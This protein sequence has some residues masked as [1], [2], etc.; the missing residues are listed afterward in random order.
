MKTLACTRILT[1]LLAVNAGVLWGAP[2]AANPTS[3]TLPSPTSYSVI[4]RDANSRVWERTVYE[5]GP[6]GQAIPKK[7]NYIELATGLHYWQN[8]QWQESQELIESFPGGAIARQGQHK[9][10]FANN[11]ATVGAIDMQTPDGKRMRSHVLG[12][13]YFDAASGQ[14][15][16]IAEVKDSLGQ[17]Y[18]PNVV[19]YSD[20][21]TD[22]KADV[23]YTYTR[24]GFEQDII[25]HERPPGP[26]AFGLNPATTR[27]QV[28]TEFL[29]PPQPVKK[30]GSLKTRSGEALDEDLDFGTMR[31]GQ[32]KAF[33]L[34]RGG[35][36]IPV[37]KQWLKLEG[38]DFLVEEVAVPELGEQ[39][40]A[41]PAAEGASLNPAADSVR[42]VVSK[43]RLL[44]ALRVVQA[45][46]NEMQLARLSLPSQ[47]LVL[48][49]TTLNSSQTSYT[50][51]GDTT[52]YISG[53]V[54]LSGTNTFEGGSVIKYD[55]GAGIGVV[56]VNPN[57]KTSPYRPVIFTA[58][59]DDSV[60][61]TI[62][63][64]SGNPSGYYAN[65]ALQIVAVHS[66]VQATMSNVRFAYATNALYIWSTLLTISN[67]QF[68]NCQYPVEL[69]VG[70]VFIRNALFSTNVTTFWEVAGYTPAI[71]LQNVTVNSA[72]HLM[73]ASA[74]VNGGVYCLTNCIFANVTGT[75]YGGIPTNYTFVCSYNGF[76]NCQHFGQNQVVDN[77]YPFQ[78]VGAG[79]YYLTNGCA[80]LNAGTK[81]IDPNL[82]AVIRTKTTRPPVTLTNAIRSSTTLGPVVPRDVDVPDL[83]Y[84]YD[85]IDYLSSCIVSNATLTINNGAVLA[86]NYSDWAYGGLWLQEGSQLISQ[87][88]ADKRNYIVDYRTA[89]EE[90]VKFWTTNTITQS[91]W[92]SKA[93][94]SFHTNLTRNPGINLNFTTV[95]SQNG[96]VYLLCA[97]NSYFLLDTLK[98]ANCELYA[99]GADVC[100]ASAPT[101][102]LFQNN[103]FVEPSLVMVSGGG[104][105]IAHNN[106]FV[107]GNNSYVE[108]DSG[109]SS[110]CI[111]QN[112]AFDGVA[113]YLEGTIGHNAYLNGAGIDSDIQASDII[114]NITWQSGPLGDY[115]QTNNSPLIDQGSATADQ[116]GLYHFTTQTNQVKEAN[117]TVDIGYHYVAV[118][119]YGMPDNVDGDGTPDYLEDANG[120]G[121]VDNGEDSWTDYTGNELTAG[122]GL[123]V[124]TPLK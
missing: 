24:A 33:S 118:D 99:C 36:D 19:I 12:L 16:L 110:V 78:T 74:E 86:Y 92:N 2:K 4:G 104:Q 83:G 88:T 94:Y 121:L 72:S 31:M 28:L 17:L 59:D 39:L 106:L 65:P 122:N 111:N 27:L 51:K 63:G 64:S 11:L 6:S 22:F 52:Y 29:N 117:S 35:E 124:L 38:R 8:G 103:L 120:N 23:R 60:G 102:R 96:S 75:F 9:V 3:I 89:Q 13:S 73:T 116:L 68:V 40:Q 50:F 76:Y 81:Y 79:N 107:G 112:N 44:P 25:L 80:F 62:S 54:Y 100:S 101:S 18:P 95:E 53:M 46:T 56:Y 108:I 109:G 115:Y 20:A 37:S 71:D 67:A 90:P 1:S 57:W 69:N 114:A 30:Q 10:I 58:K 15:V 119:V 123:L 55:R 84:H 48:D 93:F 91:L 47:G 34:E 45:G 43:Q 105:I 42:H 32:G 66:G 97:D 49:Y 77:L 41:L 5:R 70:N 113:S 87:G 14:S 7:H 61:Q 21:F 85:P 82:L 26:E 98:L